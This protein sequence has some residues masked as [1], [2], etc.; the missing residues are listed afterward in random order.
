[1]EWDREKVL[2][3]FL[4]HFPQHLSLLIL[5]PFLLLLTLLLLFGCHAGERVAYVNESVDRGT[6]LITTIVVDE[7]KPHTSFLLLLF[8][9]I[10][11]F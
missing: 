11:L 7:K 2:S 6:A 3:S 4:L 9:S 8:Y 1:M 5:L 10:F